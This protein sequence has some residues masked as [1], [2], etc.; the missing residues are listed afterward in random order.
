[1]PQP[2][3]LRRHSR[4]SLHPKWI[5]RIMP[6]R[7]GGN[8]VAVNTSARWYNT[9]TGT[10]ITASDGPIAALAALPGRAP[11]REQAFRDPMSPRGQRYLAALSF[12]FS[13]Q[14]R[15]LLNRPF[16]V[17]VRPLRRS[18]PRP[19]TPP[20]GDTEGGSSHL[21]HGDLLAVTL[22]VRRLALI[23][24][25]PRVVGAAVLGQRLTPR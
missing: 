12:N 21:K 23:S 14:C 13:D 1:M 7:A 3:D 22:R 9:P 8:H 4:S 5:K 16:F 17:V 10:N 24:A 2:G 15:F 25:Q 18:L 20:A 6:H 11:V 19:H